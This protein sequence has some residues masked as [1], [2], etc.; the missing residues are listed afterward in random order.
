MLRAD[1]VARSEDQ[2]KMMGRMAQTSEFA[3]PATPP[4]R[5]ADAAL[6]T[7]L[8][9]DDNEAALEL[10]RIMLVQRAK[11]RCNIQIAR[12]GEE[13]LQ[14]LR[15]SAGRAASIDLVLLDI[16]MPRVDG[17]EV[18][19]ELNADPALPKPAIVLCSSI[20]CRDDQERASALGAA[21]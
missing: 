15:A 1:R 14:I 17:F 16:N 12:D 13:A 3:H 7:L 4:R 21:G 9:V 20:V 18:I 8:L 5:A 10:A 19:R 11:L 2:V 6:A